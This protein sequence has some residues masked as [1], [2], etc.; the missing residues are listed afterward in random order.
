MHS[1]MPL[2]MLLRTRLF[3]RPNTQICMQLYTEAQNVFAHGYMHASICAATHLVMRAP[4]FACDDVHSLSCTTH[5]WPPHP[6]STA[7]HAM[8]HAAIDT[9][10][11]ERPHASANATMHASVHATMR[12]CTQLS[13]QP[14]CKYPNN[15]SCEF[16]CRSNSHDNACRCVC[17]DESTHAATPV[18]IHADMHAPMHTTVHAT[19]QA[20]VDDH[21]CDTTCSHILN[22]PCEYACGQT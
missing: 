17:D 4:P 7:R 14:P 8:M 9:S 6:M 12:P 1:A 18:T 16:A 10:V 22:Q 3:K 20:T 21:P 19:M 11:Q 2:Y 13:M 15:Q 5:V